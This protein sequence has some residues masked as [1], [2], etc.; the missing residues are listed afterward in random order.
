MHSTYYP[1]DDNTQNNPSTV[2]DIYPC[3]YVPYAIFLHWNKKQHYL[4]SCFNL[5]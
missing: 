5:N 2:L 3:R 4:F 1:C